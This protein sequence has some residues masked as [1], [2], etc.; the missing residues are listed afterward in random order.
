[1]YD[2]LIQR[3][4]RLEKALALSEERAKKLQ[5]EVDVLYQ[6]SENCFR[7][8]Q[9]QSRR[10]IAAI[11]RLTML[12]NKAFPTMGPMLDKLEAAIGSFDEWHK[13]NP[14]DRRTT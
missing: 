5:Y 8:H 10:V 4:M 3:I 12:E 1:M 2:V 9:A 14:L 6:N 11:E 7:T 13:D